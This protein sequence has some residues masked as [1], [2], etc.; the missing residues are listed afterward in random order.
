[1]VNRVWDKGNQYKEGFLKEYKH[2]VLEVSYGQHTLGCFIIFAK[3]EIEKISQ[4]TTE[5]IDELKNVMKNVEGAL[6]GIKEF[7]PD[8]FN[9]L[10]LGN[11]LHHLHFHGIPRYKSPRMF[12]GQKWTDS[13]WGHPPVWSETNVGDEVVIKLRDLI[14]KHL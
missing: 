2:W 3:R 8:R 9:Y 7:K 13:T 1:M 4:L 14:K 12:N 11:F 6:M 5:E 10:Q